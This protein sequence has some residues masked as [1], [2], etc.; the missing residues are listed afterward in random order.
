MRTGSINPCPFNDPASV[1]LGHVATLDCGAG[2]AGQLAFLAATE[3][4]TD[5]NI[6]GVFA[7][8]ALPVTDS[9]D[10]QLALRYEDYG[11][12]DGGDTIDPKVLIGH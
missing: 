8:L 2:G 11:S 3:E 4:S 10:I 6:Y 9:F 7:E 12:S 5:N 1:T